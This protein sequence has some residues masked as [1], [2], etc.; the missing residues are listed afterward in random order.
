M[1]IQTGFQLNSNEKQQQHTQ[2]S[3]VANH[4]SEKLN[5]IQPDSTMLSS[6]EPQ[7]ISSFPTNTPST[8]ASSTSINLANS[9]TNLN[10][11]LI[12]NEIEPINE[13]NSFKTHAT[14]SSIKKVPL[15]NQSISSKNVITTL[16]RDN[17]RRHHSHGNFIKNTHFDVVNATTNL[18]PSRSVSLFFFK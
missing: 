17:H 12:N 4:S 11:T 1:A 3:S 14:V 9:L 2:T 15:N 16:K 5:L 8:G 13:L 10:L 18:N 7:L 6:A